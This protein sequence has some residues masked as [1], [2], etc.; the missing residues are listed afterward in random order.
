M[1]AGVEGS[2]EFQ[3]ER[4]IL[5]DILLRAN[6]DETLTN[7][8]DVGYSPSDE[9]I[10]INSAAR[11]EVT[12][13]V[14]DD[15]R[16]YF[17]PS[18]SMSGRF[19]RAAE[20][21]EPIRAS[22]L[23]PV[24]R[25]FLVEEL[26]VNRAKIQHCGQ[27]I[28]KNADGLTWIKLLRQKAR[29]SRSIT[30]VA[31]GLGTAVVVERLPH[32][33]PT[34]WW[35]RAEM[36]GPFFT[37]LGPEMFAACCRDLLAEMRDKLGGTPVP[38]TIDPS[39]VAGANEFVLVDVCAE[40]L[41]LDVLLDAIRP[42]LVTDDPTK[43]LLVVVCVKDETGLDVTISEAM[44]HIGSDIALVIAG[45]AELDDLI[46][47]S[48]WVWS[49][50]FGQAEPI[51]ILRA[52]D[53]ARAKA[54]LIPAPLATLV[55]VKRQTQHPAVRNADVSPGTHL[56][57]I[58]MAGAGKS[59]ALYHLLAQRT[60]DDPVL[61]L[62]TNYGTK[63]AAL[64]SALLRYFRTTAKRITIIIDDL[65]EHREPIDLEGL[66]PEAGEAQ[67]LIDLIVTYRPTEDA[68]V[69]RKHSHLFAQS[70]TTV[71]L[72]AITAKDRQA[73]LEAIASE[74]ATALGMQID[75]AADER[76]LDEVVAT[77]QAW[78]GTPFTL[79]SELLQFE[80][81]PIRAWAVQPSTRDG[82]WAQAFRHLCEEERNDDVAIITAVSLL[83]YL[84]I[85]PVPLAL[86]RLIVTDHFQ[87]DAFTKA[88]VPALLRLERRRWLRVEDD[89]IVTHDRQVLP[90][91]IK[92]WSTSDKPER[93]AFAGWVMEHRSEIGQSWPV[94]MAGLCLQ[95]A[96]DQDAE[97]LEPLATR[98]RESDEMAG[99]AYLGIAAGLRGDH[100]RGQE[101]LQELQ[102]LIASKTPRVTRALD[103]H[104]LL[105]LLAGLVQNATGARS[106]SQ[107]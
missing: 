97:H 45:P 78:D 34:A 21:R 86:V 99:L 54:L 107:E 81:R 16:R 76:S 36:A 57:L 31:L 6:T 17:A 48:P 65:D 39:G 22:S 69:E 98:L 91:A 41:T 32:L 52:N 80:K 93:D 51:K 18:K 11:E 38:S 85:D 1:E 62:T 70:L 72:D 3:R 92:L 53:H 40:K 60:T 83:R 64:L 55:T 103:T 90:D 33:D 63:H 44:P 8:V 104:E 77:V 95:Y 66:A 35:R 59:T 100:T 10:Y 84:R 94:L 82:H 19:A 29:V 67:V 106:S 96:T 2:D 26:G 49:Q 105:R 7:R 20:C 24:D 79:V 23:L 28:V 42:T 14:G 27:V 87:S 46:S 5:Q 4:R 71:P 101:I 75:T 102:V 61:Q 68:A 58:G 73:F 12:G 89:A 43:A 56:A 47:E 30:E 37:R 15:A 9:A 88:R 13:L 50:F 74:C 25:R